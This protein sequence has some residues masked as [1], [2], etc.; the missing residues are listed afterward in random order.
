MRVLAAVDTVHTAA[1][2]CDYL[3]DR[4][5]AEDT[6]VATTVHPPESAGPTA[7]DQAVRD[8]EEA[9]NVLEVRL[10]LPTVESVER[11]GEPAPELLAAAEEQDVDELLLGVR[12]GTPGTPDG[13]GGTAEAVLAEATRPVVVVPLVEM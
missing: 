4:L 2:L 7:S 11:T 6:V 5:D 10:P 1:A 3:D 12:A 8:R 13:V 9:L